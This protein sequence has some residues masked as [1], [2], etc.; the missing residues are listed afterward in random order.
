MSEHTDS[1]GAEPIKSLR[2]IPFNAKSFEAGGYTWHVE[3][4]LSVERY[5]AFQRME[6]ELGYG[7][8]FSTLADRHKQIF[9][10]LNEGKMAEAVVIVYQLMEG[11]VAISEKTPIGL[12]VATL[13]VN[14][15]DEDRS[16]WSRSI[17]EDKLKMWNGNEKETGIDAGFFLIVA[18]S[19]VQNYGEKFKEF[20]RLSETIGSLIEKSQ[21]NLFPFGEE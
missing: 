1:Q 9:D 5:R 10:R 11:S 3:D 4:D 2:K 7:I 12:Y 8:N 14:R 20:S 13:F 6:I 15:S 18:L 17:A 16:V 19:R 21:E